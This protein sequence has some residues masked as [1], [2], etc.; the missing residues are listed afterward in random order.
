MTETKWQWHN[1]EKIKYRKNSVIHF[2]KNFKFNCI[3][4]HVFPK[5]NCNKNKPIMLVRKQQDDATTQKIIC[6]GTILLLLLYLMRFIKYVSNR[7]YYLEDRRQ[8]HLNHA[9]DPI[10]NLA[11]E[12]HNPNSEG[13][14]GREEKRSRRRRKRH[15][16]YATEQWLPKDP[17]PVEYDRY[18][19]L[20][21]TNRQKCSKFSP[22][23]MLF[24]NLLVYQ[25][26]PNQNIV[27]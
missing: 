19:W 14:N 23:I 17:C 20:C 22:L 16:K 6:Y 9:A 2:D 13:G 11:P 18:Q 7:S 21:Y 1:L 27:L 24:R 26:R 25:P 3:S 5:S 8:C 10:S 15:H 12:A 4:T